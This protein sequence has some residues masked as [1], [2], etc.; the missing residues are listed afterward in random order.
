MLQALEKTM[1][2]VSRACRQVGIDRKTHYNWLK[3]DEHYKQTVEDIA[4]AAIDFAEGQ[5]LLGIREGNTPMTIFYLK[6][7][8]KSRGYV[9]RSEHTITSDQ[10]PTWFDSVPEGYDGKSET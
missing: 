9:E 5:L 1:G 7:K 6:T 8:G 3:A 10:P 4:E 2:V